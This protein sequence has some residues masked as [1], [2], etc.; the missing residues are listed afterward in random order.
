MDFTINF[1][2]IN[3]VVVF[4]ATV[5]AIFVGG[6]WY[7]PFLFGRLWYSIS[8]KSETEG[9]SFNPTAT[10]VSSFVLQLVAAS[11]LAAILGPNAGTLVG[12]QLGTLIG[13]G[14]V[15][16]SLG[17]T[18]LFERRPLL[19]VLIKAGHH[20]VA[21]GVMGAIIGTWG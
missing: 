20:I 5:A 3:L 2:A 6:L 8:G 1:D 11:L 10:F 18:N 4:A 7:A 19:L 16:T 15:F 14:F 12:I 17:I 21:L 9:T 13:L